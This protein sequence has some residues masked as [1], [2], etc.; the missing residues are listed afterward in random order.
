MFCMFTYICFGQKK[1]KT[2]YMWWN[3][4]WVDINLCFRKMNWIDL[5]KVYDHSMKISW[6]CKARTFAF[7]LLYYFTTMWKKYVFQPI[8]ALVS[9]TLMR[10]SKILSEGYNFF[11][12]VIWFC[13]AQRCV[14][15]DSFPVDL[16]LWQ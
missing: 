5:T 9:K 10:L 7:F 3:L 6:K 16:L 14:L 15:P 2:I 1:P 4:Q 11:Y 12:T 8:T 13:N